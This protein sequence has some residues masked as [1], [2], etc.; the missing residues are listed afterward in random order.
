LSY[1]AN[2][3][4]QGPSPL[5][6]TCGPSTYSAFVP[7]IYSL[8]VMDNYNG[9]TST[10]TINVLD[11]TQP[12]V[13]T[14]PAD[15]STLDCASDYAR[16]FALLTGSN[17]GGV[18]Y[19]YYSY[20]PGAAFSPSD[21]VQTDGSN[22]LLS[23]TSSSSVNVS[24]TGTYFYVATNTVTGCQ[25]YGVFDVKNGSINAAFMPD[26]VSGYAPLAVTF[27]NTSASSLG[28]GSIISVWSFGDGTALT[29]TANV[30]PSVTYTAPGTY[31]VMLLTSKGNCLDT[32]YQVISVEIPSNLEV[33][34]IFTPNGDGS[35]DVFFLKTS[36]LGEIYA[37]IH[38]RWGN[39]VH[40]VTSSTGNIAWDGKSLNGKECAP[41]VY[42]YVINAKGR[43]GKEYQLKGNVTLMR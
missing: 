41:G 35:N 13:I 11:R 27:S 8:T 37:L 22:P 38:D 20:P 21:A 26:K 36:N 30:S 34:N 24:M 3:C 32:T 28:S 1:V 15:S 40:E 43:D 18:K 6:P 19:W 16:L 25:A 31:T 39:K 4:W 7:G 33:P 2:P 42:F 23:G 17:T 12:P 29:T 5:T 14:N 9:C 10:N